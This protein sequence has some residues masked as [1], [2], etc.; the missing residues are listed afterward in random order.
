MFKCTV[1]EIIKIEFEASQNCCCSWILEVHALACY[2][3]YL[4]YTVLLSLLTGEMPALKYQQFLPND[5]SDGAKFPV[6]LSKAKFISAMHFILMPFLSRAQNNFPQCCGSVA[7]I[8]VTILPLHWLQWNLDYTQQRGCDNKSLRL[9]NGHMAAIFTELLPRG[10][11]LL[12]WPLPVPSPAALP[13]VYPSDVTAAG[14]QLLAE[15]ASSFWAKEMGCAWQ[16]LV[17]I[18]FGLAC[19]T[20]KHPVL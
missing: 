18:S 15:L 10:N 16:E 20:S 5:S 17:P 14:T 2:D 13:N 9:H 4:N 8:H 7:R 19:S 6:M 3:L 1:W 12:M 11:L